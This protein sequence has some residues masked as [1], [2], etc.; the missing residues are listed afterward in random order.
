MQRVT[1]VHE[2]IHAWQYLD[3]GITDPGEIEDKLGLPLLGTVP[4]SDDAGPLVALQNPKSPLVEAYL[5]VQ[6]NLELATSHGAPKSVAITSTRPQEGK[7][8]TAFALA[9]SLARARR[10]VVLIDADLRSPSV[11]REFGLQNDLGVSNFLAGAGNVDAALHPTDRPGLSVMTAGPQPPNAADLLTGDRLRE[12][13]ADLLTRFDHVVVDCPPV[14][15]LADAPLVASAVEGVIYAVEARSI[16]SSVVR[17]ALARLRSSNANV[18]GVVLTKF[19]ARRAHLGYGYEYG[20]GYGGD[21]R[22]A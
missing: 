10:K 20:Y 13:I 18:L 15:G 3:E 16:R 8:T 1:V 19:D 6:T 12:L 2:L 7:S 4:R 14:M 22:K 9:H 11:H 21:A 5:A 17:V